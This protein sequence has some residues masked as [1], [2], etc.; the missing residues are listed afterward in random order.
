MKG[1]RNWRG[2][3]LEVKGREEEEKWK[4]TD[5]GGGDGEWGG[6]WVNETMGRRGIGWEEDGTRMILARR[7]VI[8][9]REGTE[10]MGG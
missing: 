6:G 7:E 2:R 8:G 4:G 10:W 3:R 5:D 1:K 9:E